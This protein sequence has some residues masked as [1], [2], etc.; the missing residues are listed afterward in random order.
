MEGMSGDGGKGEGGEG[1]K[2]DKRR[3]LITEMGGE[4]QRTASTIQYVVISSMG[5]RLIL[6]FKGGVGVITEILFGLSLV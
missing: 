5:T 1:G 2:T 3:E 6:I 4:G